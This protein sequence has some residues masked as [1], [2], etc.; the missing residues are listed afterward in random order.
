MKTTAISGRG[1]MGSGG[2]VTQ[3]R[4]PSWRGTMTERVTFRFPPSVGPPG[5]RSFREPGSHVA[6][7]RWAVAPGRLESAWG[8]C[9]LEYRAGVPAELD[10]KVPAMIRLSTCTLLALATAVSA[11]EKADVSRERACKDM[12]RLFCSPLGRTKYPPGCRGVGFPD[13]R[14]HRRPRFKQVT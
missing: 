12:R 13:Q 3:S 4:A 9:R 10:W 7:V 11:Q 6:L 14:A 5:V 8:P 1:S 2:W